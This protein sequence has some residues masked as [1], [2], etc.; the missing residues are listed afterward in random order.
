MKALVSLTCVVVLAGASYFGVQEYRR[1]GYQAAVKAYEDD[2]SARINCA[3][4]WAKQA[5]TL[6]KIIND[7]A[8]VRRPDLP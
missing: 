7:R 6:C 2:R 8:P 3:G 5:P 1:Y 4:D